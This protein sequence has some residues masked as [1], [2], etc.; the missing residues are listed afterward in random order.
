LK[1]LYEFLSAKMDGKRKTKIQISAIEGLGEGLKR[2][3]VLMGGVSVENKAL[4]R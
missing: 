4:K 3:E 2:F 1:V